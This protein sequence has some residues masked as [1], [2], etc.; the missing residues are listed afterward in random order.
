[1]LP[2]LK[3]LYTEVAFKTLPRVKE[4]GVCAS[5]DP[6]SPS[7]SALFPTPLGYPSH[8]EVGLIQR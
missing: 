3:E 8:F 6:N 4:L 5:M 1:M 2:F 7:S